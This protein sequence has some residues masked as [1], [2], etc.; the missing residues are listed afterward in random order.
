[1]TPAMIAKMREAEAEAE[2]EQLRLLNEAIRAELEKK[3]MSEN[4]K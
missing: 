2:A 1:M 4:E 3:P